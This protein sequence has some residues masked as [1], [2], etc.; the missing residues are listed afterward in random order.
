MEKNKD[1][2][3]NAIGRLPAYE[4]GHQVWLDLR[5]KL[6]EQPLKQALDTLPEYEPDGMLWE[7]IA[8]KAPAKK[9]ALIWWYAAALL[10]GGLCLGWL[11]YEKGWNRGISYSTEKADVRLQQGEP[12]LADAQYLRLKAYCETETIVCNTRD[13]RRLQEEY[14]KLND[15][16]VQLKRA[17]G[18][19]NTEASLIR[20]VTILEEQKAGIL[21]EMA[22]LI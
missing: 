12:S 15:A 8:A 10:A 11:T 6:N 17:I 9:P 14:E 22:K 21:N 18:A 1:T 7:L 2:L 19:Y 5:E 3:K 20:Q 4:P 16:S 13:Y